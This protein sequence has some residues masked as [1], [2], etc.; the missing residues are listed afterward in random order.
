M[1]KIDQ[2]ALAIYVLASSAGVLMI[3]SF[4]NMSSYNGIM[5]FI[6]MMINIRLIGGV[7]LYI[8]GFLAWLYVLSKTNLSVI[9]PMAITLSFL[10]ILILSV[11]ILKED[12]TE[13]ILIG[14]GLCLI[15]ILVILR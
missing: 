4:F 7:V 3:K 2:I 14:T 5:G 1:Q 10:A 15:G 9:Y 8:I 11:L 12:V 13:N 6:S